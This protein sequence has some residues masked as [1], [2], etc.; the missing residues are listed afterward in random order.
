MKR[1][2]T[3]QDWRDRMAAQ[4]RYRMKARGLSHED[5]AHESG[6]PLEYIRRIVSAAVYPTHKARTM[7]AKPLGCTLE[8]VKPVIKD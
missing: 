1:E 2:P 4:V 6:L 5:L 3:L 8:F 7:I